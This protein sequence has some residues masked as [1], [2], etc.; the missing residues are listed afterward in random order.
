LLLSAQRF[1]KVVK[2][3]R[4]DISADGV[5]A[6]PKEDREKGNAGD[7]KLP[8]LALAIIAAQPIIDYNPYVFPGTGRYRP[9]SGRYP[10][11]SPHFA[12]GSQRKRDLDAMLPAKMPHWTLHDLRRTARSL[13][14]KVGV[15]DNIAER[16]LGHA[17]G[18]VQ[19][20]YNRHAYFDEKADALARLASCVETI[21]NPPD[22]TNVVPLAARS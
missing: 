15:A 19:G 4:S 8:E 5:W 21:L 13:M 11:A 3:R 7:L 20:I 6:I 22:K 16:V 17:I 18:G 2:M 9:G 14:A 12:S 1:D 10:N